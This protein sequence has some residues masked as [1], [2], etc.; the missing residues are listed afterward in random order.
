M[1]RRGVIHGDLS[2]Y[3]ILYWEGK[4]VLIDFPQITDSL[5]NRHAREI[6]QRDIERVCEYFRRQGVRSDATALL[7]D[8]WTRHVRE[9]A[10]SNVRDE[11]PEFIE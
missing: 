8:L 11:M 9:D 7:N 5:T 10:A 2:A 3:N 1:L 4:V 6:L